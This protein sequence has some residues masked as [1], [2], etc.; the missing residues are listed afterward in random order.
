MTLKFYNFLNHKKEIFKPV[1][2]G[3]VGLYTCGPTVYNYAHI[4]NLRTYVFEDVLRRVLEY[5]GYKV[6]HI[7]NITDVGHL[8]SNADAGEDK[9]E[10]EA[11]KTHRNVWEI[12]KFYT[13]AFL[14]DLDR[15]NII[16]AQKLI[17]ATS[18]IKQQIKMIKIL[19]KMDYAYDTPT[20]V[21]FNVPK[22]K[23]Y[24]RY[25]G[26]PLKNL[27]T[28]AR[29]EVVSDS[30]KQHPADFALWFK[31]TGRFKNHIM[32][33]PSPW[34]DG[35]PGWHIECSAISSENLGQP[36]D[37]HTGAVDHV[38]PHHSNEIA[39]SEAAYGKKLACYWL[40]GEHLIIENK[41]MGKSLGNFY[42]INDL[43]N[44]KINPLAFRYLVLGAHYRSQLNFTWESLRAAE[45]ALDRLYDF[46]LM[47]RQ[48]SSVSSRLTLPR[49]T[50][51]SDAT[52]KLRNFVSNKEKPAV[53]QTNFQKAV[54]D[55]LNTPKALA[56]LW[57]LV[58]SYNKNPDKF[59]PELV[60]KT[61]YKFDKIFGLKLKETRARKIPEE[62]LKLMRERKEARESK[63]F[64]LAD[65]IR[66]KIQSL[67]WQ[68]DDTPSG[69]QLLHFSHAK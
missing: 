41:R 68:I 67:G 28:G 32:R 51:G 58:R 60:L 43:E 38:F 35:F 37:I 7:M 18:Y 45:S 21:Y 57:E 15:L 44:K 34:G 66:N 11:K 31:L 1:K 9:I 39:Q 4:G 63:N 16:R 48:N 2:K 62:V 3:K 61:I 52:Q 33:W 46:I 50:G 25:S 29:S 27:I 42:T 55:D 5:G 6:K 13:K 47:L 54:F 22:F 10:K 36:F 56:I 69:S 23:N 65:K 24:A 30:Q 14:Y 64:A 59:D 19:I 20:A 12:T 53:D 26:Q 17:P 40:E 8:T 49:N